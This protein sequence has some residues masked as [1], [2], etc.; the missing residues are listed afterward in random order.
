MRLK[1]PKR[2]SRDPHEVNKSCILDGTK[3]NPEIF[4]CYFAFHRS[5][6]IGI[7]HFMGN[8]HSLSYY[9]EAPKKYGGL[10]LLKL[11]FDFS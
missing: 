2:T 11:M 8:K 4:F 5:K 9:D 6:V 1:K 7:L 3:Y 10:F